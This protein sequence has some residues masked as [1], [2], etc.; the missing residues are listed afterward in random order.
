M[1]KYQD[2]KSVK[3]IEQTI[4]FVENL[5]GCSFKPTGKYRYSSYCPFHDDRKDSFRLYVDGKD[6]VKFHCFG[7][8][9]GNWDVYDLIIKKKDCHF[10]QAQKE[11]AEFLDIKDITFHKEYSSNVPKEAG[12]EENEPDITVDITEPEELH[13]KV[14]EAL[15]EA[16][17]FYN[18]L[19]LDNPDKFG[20]VHK[21]LNHRGLNADIIRLFK[22]GYAPPLPD[23]E[24]KGR[25]LMMECQDRFMK[26]H[27][28]SY[29]YRKA[30]LIR[31]LED[32]TSPG[33][34]Y[35]RRYISSVKEWGAYNVWAD[36]FANRI[37]FPIHDINGKPH[38]FMGRKIDNRDYRWIRQSSEDTF[39]KTQSWLFGIDKAARHIK[40]YESVILVEGIFDYFAFYR[41]L[42]DTGR[43]F[44]VST[45]GTIFTEEIRNILQGLGVKNYIVA[46]D[47]D[48]TGRK[49]I[50]KVIEK[51]G[52]TVF[53][54]GGMKE[55]EDPADK[56]EQVSTVIN[57]FSVKHLS[58]AAKEIQK[59][60][61][62]PVSMSFISSGKPGKRNVMFTP[63]REPIPEPKE[64]AKEYFYNI[65]EFLPLL[66]YDSP[67]KAALD[68]KLEQI[69]QLLDTK[70]VKATSDK[71]FKI[72][73]NFIRQQN[74]KGIG[75]AIILWLRIVIE[76]Q[77]RKRKVRETDG[78]VSQWLNTSRKTVSKY[79]QELNELGYLNIDTSHKLQRLSVKFFT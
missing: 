67:N 18:K 45:L 53:Y 8:C 27:R 7:A 77:N 73:G 48:E 41:I 55:D 13:P 38:G 40:H 59:K 5:L 3:Y 71:V 17:E 28:V 29:Y 25:A 75:P 62:K 11:F 36:Y 39:I 69:Y 42:Q 70:P 79:K 37:T 47:W 30:G 65:D 44:V 60:T 26:D 64:T 32:E 56:L 2:L 61:D 19:L 43:P 50:H 78:T 58:S 63:A 9:H 23:D 68:A 1:T 20:A 6:Q 24:Y 35:Y 10:R 31:L 46:Y 66:S 54:L 52:A 57:G 22:I 74:Y 4:V 76:Q 72:P 33:Y 12:K 21:Y 34:N 15:E 16:A 49:A 51:T 14:I